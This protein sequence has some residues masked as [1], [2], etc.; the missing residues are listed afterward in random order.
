MRCVC[1]RA[2]ACPPQPGPR[3]AHCVV[4]QQPSSWA[5]WTRLSLAAR[6]G[7]T[8]VG[9]RASQLL[10]AWLLALSRP[11]TVR[12]RLFNTNTRRGRQLP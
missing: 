5:P 8:Y 11:L 6:P 2:P 1:E 4:P 3:L 10:I 9:G 7:Y 12:P